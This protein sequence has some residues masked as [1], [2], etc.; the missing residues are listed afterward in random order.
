MD[1]AG[2]PWETI[3]VAVKGEIPLLMSSVLVVV[4][5]VLSVALVMTFRMNSTLR[6][7]CS[8]DYLPPFLTG[9]RFVELPN[10]FE[11]RMEHFELD[12][13]PPYSVSEDPESGS[14]YSQCSGGN[15]HSVPTPVPSTTAI[16]L[17]E[18]LDIG[19][20]GGDDL[21][22]RDVSPQPL[23]AGEDKVPKRGESVPEKR[24]IPST[25]ENFKNEEVT[26]VGDEGG[27][28]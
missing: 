25:S 16:P 20:S 7:N 27:K 28:I 2:L 13:L 4:V 17:A 11:G 12:S 10:D 1:H 24:S 21:G 26:S 6:R 8:A 23:R 15:R 3:L 9:S 5:A 22:V 19:E 18:S 14:S